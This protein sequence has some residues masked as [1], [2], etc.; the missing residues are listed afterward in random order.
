MYPKEGGL[1]SLLFTRAPRSRV[2]LILDMDEE[3]VQRRVAKTVA[4]EL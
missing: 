3:H 4:S 2:L 1:S